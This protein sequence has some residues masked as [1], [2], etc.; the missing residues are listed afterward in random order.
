[1]RALGVRRI[2]EITPEIV[3]EFV[4]RFGAVHFSR[5]FSMTHNAQS[6]AEKRE[7]LLTVSRLEAHDTLARFDN[8]PISYVEFL[9]YFLIP[10]WDNLVTRFA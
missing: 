5:G 6:S 2:W 8:H 4:E 1:M 9:D 3:D 7:F 10:L